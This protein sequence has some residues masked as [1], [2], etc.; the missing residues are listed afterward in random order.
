[1]T[2][3][4]SLW[5]PSIV[6][7][8]LAVALL[9]TAA[10]D[11]A[12]TLDGAATPVNVVLDVSDSVSD[13]QLQTVWTTLHRQLDDLPG[14]GEVRIIQFAEATAVMPYDAGPARAF[15]RPADVAGH[16]TDIEAA[17]RRVAGTTDDAPRT[18]TLLVSDGRANHGDVR[19]ALPGAPS[20]SH[21]L[22]WWDITGGTTPDT[23]VTLDVTLPDRAQVHASVPLQAQ[24]H[25]AAVTE[26]S[27][28]VT[29]DD[30]PLTAVT[31]AATPGEPVQMTFPVPIAQTGFHRV[32]TTLRIGGAA[33]ERRVR[34]VEAVGLAPVVY[35][36][37]RSD[38]EIAAALRRGGWSTTV[39][40]PAQLRDT[41]LR[42]AGLVILDDIAV[43]AMPNQMWE[44]LVA[45][46]YRD[47]L[48]LIV[49]GGRHTYADGGYRH[50]QLEDALPL[51]AEGRRPHSKAAVMFVEDVSGSME[52]LHAASGIRR[53][54]IANQ[55]V[56]ETA[57]QLD[58]T[59][60]FGLVTFDAAA[61]L[62]I[63]LGP[64]QQR[65]LDQIHDTQLQ[66]AGGTRLS[67]GLALALDQLDANPADEKIIVLVSDAQVEG[68]DTLQPIRDRLAS[69]DV[70]VIALAIDEA[71]QDAS[72]SAFAALCDVNDGRLVTVRET[73][74]LPALMQRELV[75]Q[76]KA[77]VDSVTRAQLTA[78]FPFDVPAIA[79]TPE[80]DG[81]M[82]ARTK[83]D[84]MTY[85]AADN[86]DPIAAGWRYGNGR[87]IAFTT[88][89]GSWHRGWPAW[90][91]FLGA[92]SEWAGASHTT[93]SLFSRHTIEDDELRIMV[94]AVDTSRDWA[95]SRRLV[96]TLKDPAGRLSTTSLNLTAPGRFEVRVPAPLEGRYDYWIR[97]RDDPAGSGLRGALFR[98][99]SDTGPD[100]ARQLLALHQAVLDGV[101]ERVDLERQA[102][103]ERLPQGRY[104]LSRWLI[105]LALLSYV[106]TLVI[107]RDLLRTWIARVNPEVHG[108]AA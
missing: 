24:I 58:P 75:Q 31:F 7:R 12:I 62:R 96:L 65:R 47:G 89:L 85:L 23:P 91:V 102:L 19:R 107:E 83:D 61:Q 36:S 76:R 27:I 45:S 69:V 71:S 60:Q 10:V 90:G 49:I 92:I 53:I 68:A 97:D 94:D 14:D 88:D 30:R 44:Q 15:Q 57:R 54:E 13:A 84:A 2:V 80:L 106:A 41:D 26:G 55:A 87:V 78:P 3:A 73:L 103:A 40:R 70:S 25:T 34:I 81:Y 93:T 29:V 86:G 51:T 77:R 74:D 6:G 9:L 100:D 72:P 17:L 108:G 28:D 48:G 46:V 35:V 105:A 4:P 43:D 104:P 56:F 63:P 11:P 66:P 8:L 38:P 95:Q 37:N 22:L 39:R 1:M 52:R 20:P 21:P 79:S 59:D 33:V 42:G 32:E 82:L 99:L 64:V 98:Q 101:V 5:R 18:L 50:S 67:A 16:R